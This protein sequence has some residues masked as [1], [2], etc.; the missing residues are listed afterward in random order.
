MRKL[1]FVDPTPGDEL[2]LTLDWRLQLIAER[3]L[4]AQLKAWSAKTHR[5]LSGAVVAID[6]ADGGIM[7]LASYP[8]YDPNYFATGISGRK[9]AHYVLDSSRPL[10]DRAIGAATPTGSTFKMVTGSGGISSGVIKP[11]QILYDSGSWNCH[12]F[13][14]VD[15]A[16]GGLG[17]T[18]FVHALAASS[19]GYFYQ[20]ADRLGHARLR[21]YAE[22]YGLNAISGI[23][24]PNEYEG[25]WPTNAWSMKI[26]H[27]P[28][29][30]SDVCQLGIGQGAMQATPLQIANVAATVVD[31]GVLHRPHLVQ[32]IRTPNGRIIK[33]IDAPMIRRVPVTQIALR[34]VR[35]GMAQ[36]TEPWGTAYGLAIPGL[37]FA[38]K[39]GTVETQGGNG[40]NTT[41]FVAYAP[42]DHPKI[43]MAVFMEQTGSYGATVA[44]PV[45]QRVL[46][47]YFHKKLPE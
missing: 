7:A 15:L 27:L 21:Y 9:S 13:T 42:V 1:G 34:E 37:P 32:A 28:L 40:P 38:G 30:P 43:A 46:A 36:V 24:L 23:D 6:P 2:V 3:A 41:W 16:S 20:V 8:N 14:F 31:G 45:A 35:A 22:Q 39:T 5:R 19:D 44:A 25:N 12:G 4:A 18:D 11:D 47:E 29:E 17:T 26:Y 10:F 33:R